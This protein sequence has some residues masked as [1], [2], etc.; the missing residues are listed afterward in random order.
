[1]LMTAHVRDEGIS[2]RPA[3]LSRVLREQLA[4]K[5]L[6]FQGVIV[7]DALGMA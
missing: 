2:D 7:T 6:G 4:R 3:T 1:M 5:E